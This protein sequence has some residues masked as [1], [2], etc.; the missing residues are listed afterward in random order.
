MLHLFL[1][2]NNADIQS[3]RPYHMNLSAHRKTYLYQERFSQDFQETNLR[4]SL[5]K[6]INMMA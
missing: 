5:S 6:R 4:Y 1:I 2:L 3:R